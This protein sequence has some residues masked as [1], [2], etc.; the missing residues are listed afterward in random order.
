MALDKVKIQAGILLPNANFALD[1]D[2]NGTPDGYSLE[3][4]F[5]A[6][7]CLCLLA[8]PG[9]GGYSL[10]NLR[11]L[12]VRMPI[13][14][15][16]A[17]DRYIKG[18]RSALGVFPGAA[19]DLQ[20]K[21]SINYS[22]KMT[23]Q[24]TPTTISLRLKLQVQD[25]DESKSVIE[26]ERQFTAADLT[27]VWVHAT[28]YGQILSADWG[29]DF[30]DHARILIVCE[31][32]SSGSQNCDFFLDNVTVGLHPFDGNANYEYEVP[33]EFSMEGLQ[34]PSM[35][36]G[37]EERF[38]SGKHRIIDPSGGLDKKR[39]QLPFRYLPQAVYQR[40][41]EFW[42]MNRGLTDVGTTQ[43][44]IGQ[45]WPLVVKPNLKGIPHSV[46]CNWLDRH[47]PFSAHDGGYV[48]ES[49]PRYQGVATF[50]EI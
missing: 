50:E 48:S 30:P 20:W 23:G 32:N 28:S 43:Y 38:F 16:Y 35:S 13:N 42:R 10:G 47:F 33:V 44:K 9:R 6:D 34:F 37:T 8:D 12:N 17:T 2:E 29:S 11:S 7:G 1:T 26:I 3:G 27:S 4:D 36:L 40:L 46:Y 25:D 5:T 24:A 31:Q 41:Y 21:I 22:Y 15:P 45:Q 14:L 49:D 19:R 18:P 39:F